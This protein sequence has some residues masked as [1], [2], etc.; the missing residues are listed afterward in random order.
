MN[1]EETRKL[2]EEINNPAVRS[3]ISTFN[4]NSLKILR[5]IKES[6]KSSQT[7]ND[8]G[9]LIKMLSADNPDMAAD[10]DVSLNKYRQNKREDEESG[11]TQ[12]SFR[13]LF[14][15]VVRGELYEEVRFLYANHA[16]PDK[17]KSFLSGKSEEEKNILMGLAVKDYHNTNYDDGTFK[18]LNNILK[19][20][21]RRISRRV[22][23]RVG[24]K[25]GVTLSPEENQMIRCVMNG[26]FY[27]PE[28]ENAYSPV[29]QKCRF[30]KPKN[31]YLGIKDYDLLNNN[32]LFREASSSMNI[33]LL[34]P[35]IV[36]A[37]SRSGISVQEA[38]QLNFSDVAE[39]MRQNSPDGKIS[40]KS[41][42]PECENNPR[43]EFCRKLLENEETLKAVKRDFI[44]NGASPEYFEYWRQSVLN[45]G[46]PN[47]K[48]HQGEFAGRIPVI[49][50]H[51]KEHVNYAK[52]KNDM[53]EINDASNF[54]MIVAF[55]ENDPHKTE[56]L[57]D[58][59]KVMYINRQKNSRRDPS[60]LNKDRPEDDD[61]AVSEM[62]SFINENDGRDTRAYVSPTLSLSRADI[63]GNS[64][65]ARKNTVEK[66][67]HKTAAPAIIGQMAAA[68]A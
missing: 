30:R 22:L 49:T 1:K 68:R 48:V 21:N 28:D 43:R 4:D 44:A 32:P 60:L 2:E 24:D 62:F 38:A 11:Q 47:P 37:L 26:S 59:D 18:K 56:H 35:L 34:E 50:I 52:T 7:W 57:G 46:N 51:H 42:S 58:N 54:S 67:Q 15:K 16:S 17:L 3:R 66:Q 55:G 53:L 10:L 23:G 36:R 25:G 64:D 27:L 45:D 9:K 29:W 13:N 14:E 33:R 63:K 19:A 31:N 12:K 61:I 20:F 5:L 8:A 6:L 40:F 41:L 39:L 65:M